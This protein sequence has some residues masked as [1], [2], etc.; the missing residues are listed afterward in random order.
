[1]DSTELCGNQNLDLPDEFT[2]EVFDSVSLVHND[3]FPVEVLQTP[4]RK[5]R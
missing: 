1:M 2:L 3:I 5:R 4:A